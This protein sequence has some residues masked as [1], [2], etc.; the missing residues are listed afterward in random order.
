MVA[1][2]KNPD[3]NTTAEPPPKPLRL[4]VNVATIGEPAAGFTSSV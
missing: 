2:V 3:A 1:G 4:A